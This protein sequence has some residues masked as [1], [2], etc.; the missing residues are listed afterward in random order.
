MALL[1]FKIETRRSIRLAE[2]AAVPRVMVIAGK[3]G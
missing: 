3:K 2:V 1:S